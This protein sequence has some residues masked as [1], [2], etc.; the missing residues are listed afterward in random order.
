MGAA[1]VVVVVVAMAVVVRGMVVVVRILEEEEV[2]CF[3][4]VFAAVVVVV[5]GMR[6]DDDDDTTREVVE[7][8]EEEGRNDV[9]EDAKTV[10]VL[11]DD[12]DDD[13]TNNANADAGDVPG[14]RGPEEEE[15]DAVSASIAALLDRAVSEAALSATVVLELRAVLARV[16]C[17]E[18]ELRIRAVELAALSRRVDELMTMVSRGDEEEEGGGVPCGVEVGSCCCASGVTMGA[19]LT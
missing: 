6:D 13:D 15:E 8:E 11:A 2:C 17:I 14:A 19:T 18:Y 16:D 10:V 5:V 1:V 12:D 4:V 7:E 9:D 3:V